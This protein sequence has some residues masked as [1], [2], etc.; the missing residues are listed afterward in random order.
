MTI[1]TISIIF[2]QM[3][4]MVTR[5]VTVVLR[6]P[7][8]MAGGALRVDIERT[9]CPAGRSLTTVTTGV[10]ACAAVEARRAATLIVKAG[11]N[12][13]LSAAIIM[14]CATVAGVTVRAG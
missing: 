11:Q 2:T 13:D 4:T 6:C 12:T 7:G 8:S 9:G 10:G 3:L 5:I 14:V 1:E